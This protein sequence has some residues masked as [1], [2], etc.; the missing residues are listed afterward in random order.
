MTARIAV[1]LLTMSAAAAAQSSSG[2]LFIGGGG[3]SSSGEKTG[4][5]VH[6]GGGADIIVAK[7]LGVNGEFGALLGTIYESAGFGSFSPGVS[8]H[9]LRGKDRK[10]D[11]F[12]TGG[13]TLMFNSHR[14]NSL[15]HF[16]GGVTYWTSR[17]FGV[18]AEFRDQVG[19]ASG[20]LN[21]AHGSAMH[22]WEIRAALAFR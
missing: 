11:P 17:R 2:Y 3:I 1:L 6:A 22:F 12:F 16:G 21:R 8:Y 13:Y 9:F 18:R 15:F 7:G 10:V 19:K 20:F 4:T 14:Q 5:S